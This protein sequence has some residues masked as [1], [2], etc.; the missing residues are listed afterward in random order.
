MFWGKVFTGVYVN[1]ARHFL[2]SEIPRWRTYTGSSYNFATEKDTKV[3]STAVAM[4]QACLIHLHQHRHCP[5]R[6]NTIRCKLE[7]ETVTKTGSTNNLATET[8]IDANFWG[9]KCRAKSTYTPVKTLPQN[10]GIATEIA[11]ISV[12]V[13]KLLLLPVCT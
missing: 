2:P 8:D 13:A 7:V 1:F 5:T 3:I 10:I 6:H 12:S 4:Y 11:L 9:R